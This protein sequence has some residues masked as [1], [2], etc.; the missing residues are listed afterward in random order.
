MTYKYLQNELLDALTPH[1]K[2]IEGFVAISLVRFRN[3]SVVAELSVAFL[4][5]SNE[6]DEYFLRQTIINAADARGNIGQL[7]FDIFFLENSVR[8]TTEEPDDTKD[9]FPLP[10]S[11]IGIISGAVLLIILAVV[12]GVSRYTLLHSL[13]MVNAWERF[14]FTSC[15]AIDFY[16]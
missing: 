10:D 5:P 1:F 7:T 2:E 3:G 14:S 15:D 16:K 12:F 11:A 8:R 13:L 9:D 6:V 4:S